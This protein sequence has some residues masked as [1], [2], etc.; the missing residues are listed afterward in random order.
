MNNY[1]YPAG[2]G[3]ISQFTLLITIS[4]NITIKNGMKETDIFTT[5]SILPISLKIRLKMLMAVSGP[6]ISIKLDL[7]QEESTTSITL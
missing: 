4:N 1:N 3:K 2:L 7:D 6:L 5:I